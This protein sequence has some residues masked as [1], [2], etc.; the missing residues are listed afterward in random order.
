MKVAHLMNAS[1]LVISASEPLKLAAQMML[2]SGAC[3][4]LAVGLALFLTL[5]KKRPEQPPSPMV[6]FGT[7][8][9]TY[10]YFTCTT[11][12]IQSVDAIA[13]R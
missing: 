6:D 3:F 9:A 10:A 8:V 12:L 1:P 7:L 4:V 13:R 11:A 5:S 2:E